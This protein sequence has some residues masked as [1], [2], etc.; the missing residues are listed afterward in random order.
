MK[1]KSEIAPPEANGQSKLEAD[2]YQRHVLAII[3]LIAALGFSQSL[4]ALAVQDRFLLKDGLDWIYDLV[5]W[6]IVLAVFGRSKTLEQIV[7]LAI[8]GMML[9][10]AFH[11]GFD[12]WDKLGASRRAERLVTGWS[13]FSAITVAIIVM[14]LMAAFRLNGNPLIR[15][16]W[17]SSRNDAIS[18]A[19]FALSGFEARV[20]TS[21]WPEI[22]L[23]LLVIGLSLQAAYVILGEIW[24]HFQS[25][26]KDAWK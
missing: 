25:S 10:A 2:R 14:V 17:L 9:V 15:A 23:D 7:A 20:S 6:S 12:L 5:L 3:L 16:T 13:G 21:Q 26:P 24:R 8:A 19:A 1:P 18:T 4:Y 22:L 11:A